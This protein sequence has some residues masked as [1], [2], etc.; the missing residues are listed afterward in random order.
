MRLFGQFGIDL[1]HDIGYPGAVQFDR[2]DLDLFCQEFQDIHPDFHRFDRNIGFQ[3]ILR[4]T[5]RDVRNFQCG[6]SGERDPDIADTDRHTELLG[7]FGFGERFDLFRG[8]Q[9]CGENDRD[10][11]QPD[12]YHCEICQ[13]F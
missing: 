2:D 5:E 4:R 9:E 11:K 7:G 1:L 3:R 12:E 10:D 13:Y 6:Y 8:E